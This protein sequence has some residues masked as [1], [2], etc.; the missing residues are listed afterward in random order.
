MTTQEQMF[1]VLIIVG[2]IF[3]ILTNVALYYYGEYRTLRKKYE[4]G[5]DLHVKIDDFVERRNRKIQEER[6]SR[7]EERLDNFVS[8]E[9]DNR[10]D[11]KNDLFVM[12]QEVDLIKFAKGVDNGGFLDRVKKLED[13]MIN[14]TY[15]VTKLENDDDIV[16]R[17]FLFGKLR[18]IDRRVYDIKDMVNGGKGVNDGSKK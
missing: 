11:L 14:T 10:N 8:T 1:G 17:E 3:S 5:E 15:R 7:L 4:S 9:I 6:I 2:V 12:G 13:S 18:E 16:R